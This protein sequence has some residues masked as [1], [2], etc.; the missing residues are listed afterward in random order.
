VLPCRIGCGLIPEGVEFFITDGDLH[1]SLYTAE[2]LSLRLALSSG[3][4][5]GTLFFM[6]CLID[7][8]GL[9]VI[10]VPLDPID[11]S[12]DTKEEQRT[13]GGPHQ[14]RSGPDRDC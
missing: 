3:S 11:F 14:I 2:W 8:N 6:T 4:I 1:D 10:L 13:T 5:V 7:T 9:L 12:Q